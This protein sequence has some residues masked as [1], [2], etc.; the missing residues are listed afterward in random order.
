MDLLTFFQKCDGIVR[1]R[2]EDFRTLGW[3]YNDY[4]R[5]MSF[6]DEIRAATIMSPF[7][8]KSFG[9]K[10]LDGE[11]L[12]ESLVAQRVEAL[13]SWLSTFS[14]DPLPE[15]KGAYHWMMISRTYDNQG[16]YSLVYSNPNPGLLYQSSFHFTAW[17]ELYIAKILHNEPI[18]D[19]SQCFEDPEKLT[20]E[21]LRKR[22]KE[23][24]FDIDH[25]EEP[26]FPDDVDHYVSLVRWAKDQERFDRIMDLKEE[27]GTYEEI[28]EKRKTPVFRPK[29]YILYIYQWGNII[30]HKYKHDLVDVNC[31][32]PSLDGRIT[33]NA[34]FCRNCRKFIVSQTAYENYKRIYK[35]IPIRFQYVNDDG[36]FPKSIYSTERQAQ[37]PLYLAGYTVS[38]K[39]GYSD[40]KRQKILIALIQTGGMEKHEIL[41][42]LE[43]FINTNGQNQNM[44]AA[45]KK[46][47]RDLWF[48]LDYNMENQDTFNMERIEQY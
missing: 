32:I 39:A 25:R 6:C 12:R 20:E 19:F 31:N 36:T 35:M 48:L 11:K 21:E 47:E 7:V 38:S 33:I 24:T 15:P 43:L 46:W 18:I 45:L 41:R 17:I 26:P 23:L 1:L 4:F 28:L 40:A 42:Y 16:A 13:F 37:S 9:I 27:R 22:I 3:S 29:E 8:Q 30:C 2:Y 5:Y 14:D 34:Q 44:V 10:L